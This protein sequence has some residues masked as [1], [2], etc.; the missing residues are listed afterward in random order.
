MSGTEGLAPPRLALLDLHILV[1]IANDFLLAVLTRLDHKLLLGVIG[2]SPWL[3]ARHRLLIDPATLLVIQP[4]YLRCLAVFLATFFGWLECC[5]P[6]LVSARFLRVVAAYS[7][8]DSDFI[9]FSGKY[10]SP[11]AFLP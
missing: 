10:R 9:A 4:H 1:T 6:F 8:E 7:F 3:V 11:V 2:R 5:L